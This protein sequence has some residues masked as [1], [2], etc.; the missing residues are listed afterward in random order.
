[1]LYIIRMSR[2]LLFID[3]AGDVGFKF[4][5]GSTDYFAIAVVFFDDDL[6]A[7]EAS[8]RIKRM[9]RSLGWHDLH[10]FKFRKTSSD[11]KIQFFETVCSLDFRVVVALID[12]RA[13]TQNAP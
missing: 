2:K 10:E 13:V 12:K 5:Q 8:L 6:D 11:I 3:D 1:M 4:G 9:R 7:E